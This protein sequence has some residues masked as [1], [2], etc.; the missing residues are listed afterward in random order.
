MDLSVYIQLILLCV[1]NIILIFSGVVS[2]T[3]VMI[4]FWKSSELQK[5]L[6]HFRIMVLSFF[7]LFAVLT[8]NLGLL[9][10]LIY[11]LREDY[12]LLPIWKMYLDFVSIFA[13]LSF[14][15]LHIMSIERYLGAYHPI[16]YR[17]SLTR[18]RLLTLLAILL[19][20]QVSLNVISR[21]DAII[22]KALNVLIF[23]IAVFPPLLYLNVKL[24]K[25][26]SE[27]R[28]RNAI[29]PEKRTIINLKSISTCLLTVACLVV[30]SISS[31]VYIVLNM[32]TKSKP[33]SNAMLSRMWG[34][35]IFTMSC[36]FNS[37]IFFW[38]NKVLRTEGIMILKTLKDR[39]VGS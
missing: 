28:R 11:W 23:I 21:N 3:L 2:N 15:T 38:K 9:I 7:D 35:T 36:T 29:S 13:G 4:S 39:L 10:Y 31:S 27:V 32:T 26:S 19:S 18:R 20:F 25:M 24:F 14:L 17:K 5:K 30:V 1:V 22:P 34:T 8:N 12:D 33:S 6:C 37:L 16:F